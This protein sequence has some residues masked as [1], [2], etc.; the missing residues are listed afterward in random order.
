MQQKKRAPRRISFKRPAA[1]AGLHPLISGRFYALIFKCWKMRKNS[2]R[3][4]RTPKQAAHMIRLHILTLSI[5]EYIHIIYILIW[6]I[7]T[8]YM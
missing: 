1:S 7:D 8:I 3:I 4:S 2:G 6:H 5:Y